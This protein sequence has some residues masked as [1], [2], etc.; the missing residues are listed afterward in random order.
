M[1][2]ANVRVAALEVPLVAFGVPLVAVAIRV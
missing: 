1:M 2:N